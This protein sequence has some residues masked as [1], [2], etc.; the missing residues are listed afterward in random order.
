MKTITVFTPTYNRAY[1]LHQLYESLLRQT[2]KDFEW[3]V[4]D[5][6]STDDTKSLV[7]KWRTESKVSI[8]YHYKDNGGMHTGHNAA[9]GLIDTELNI[10][11]DSDDYLADD[12]I[13][14]IV[15]FW[16]SNKR[17]GCAGILAL[18]S[19]KDG[20]LVSSKKFPGNVKS[21]KYSLLKRRYGI[22]G[23]VKFIYATEVIKK[24]EDYP[25]FKDEKFVPLGYKY[26]L[27]DKAYDMFFFNKVVCIVDYLP[28]GS[29]LNMFRQYYNNPIGFT[30]S[31]KKSLTGL[32]SFIE[33]IIIGT[34]LV[35]ESF[36]ARVNMFENN[37]NKIITL[38]SIPSGL[39]LYFFILLKN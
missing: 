36:L 6:G 21:G 20:K 25:V 18:N 27:I 15:D 32:Y 16:A 29:T 13:E 8:L 31:R 14:S 28:D 39:L 5:D 38:L 23:D 10:C 12:A 30:F 37:Q 22:S 24:F 17:E 33:K 2:S 7:D 34:H 19:Y 1:C 9:L 11:I 4:I 26:A 35:A 3:L